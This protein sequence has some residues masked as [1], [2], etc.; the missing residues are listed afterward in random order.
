MIREA[1]QEM[2]AQSELVAKAKHATVVTEIPTDGRTVWVEHDGKLFIQSVPPDLRDHKVDSVFDLCEA[3]KLWNPNPVV[4]IDDENIV[5]VVDDK[6]RRETVTLKLVKS[7]VFRKLLDLRNSS[8]LSQVDL[9]RL[10][11][12]DLRNTANVAPL[13]MAVRKVKFRSLTEGSNIIQHGNESMGKT[14]ENEVTG[15]DAIAES[16][17]VETNLYSNPGE[18]DEKFAINLDLEIDAAKACFYLRPMPDEI[19]LATQM[20]LA[21]IRERI[22]RDAHG[23]PVFFGRP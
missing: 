17:L 1:L 9:I 7:F 11:R 14:I 15:A 6:D 21:G 22:E 8:K 19:E 18:A 20:A 16:L 13:L 2:K 10:L 4:W 12:V 5:L 23:V 3:A